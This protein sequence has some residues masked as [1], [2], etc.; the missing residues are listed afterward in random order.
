MVMPSSHGCFENSI[1][2][3]LQMPSWPGIYGQLEGA[4]AIRWGGAI[5]WSGEVPRGPLWHQHVSFPLLHCTRPLSDSLT[6]TCCCPPLL[7]SSLPKFTWQEGQK[8]LPLIGCVLLLIALV[9]SLIILREFN[10]GSRGGHWSWPSRMGSMDGGTP[11][12]DRSG[13]HT[14]IWLLCPTDTPA[15]GRGPR[16]LQPPLKPL[17]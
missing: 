4:V 15:K 14:L 16:G 8:R 3:H 9:V 11:Q 2:E 10:A 12:G 13:E 6:L 1:R 5:F 7:G 17:G